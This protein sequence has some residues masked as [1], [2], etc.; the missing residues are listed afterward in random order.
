MYK[1]MAIANY[2]D[3]FA[4]PTAH[5][6]QN[7]AGADIRG[8]CGF[9]DGNGCSTGSTSKSLFGGAKKRG[10]TIPEAMQS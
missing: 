3:R 5:R 1:I 6:E 4:I 7:E 9:T 8:G 2:E 10:F